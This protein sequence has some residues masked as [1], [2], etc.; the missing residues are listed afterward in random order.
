MLVT[1]FGGTSVVDA[2]AR[3]LA[4]GP[5]ENQMRDLFARTETPARAKS[6]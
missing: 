3:D 2:S 6:S 5:I 1:A 4:S